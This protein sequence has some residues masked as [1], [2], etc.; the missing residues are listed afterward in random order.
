MDTCICFWF[1]ALLD[2]LADNGVLSGE[3]VV[4]AVHVVAVKVRWAVASVIGSGT[5]ISDRVR[6]FRP[7]SVWS[8]GVSM[9]VVSELRPVSKPTLFKALLGHASRSV[10]PSKVTI[11]AVCRQSHPAEPPHLVRRSCARS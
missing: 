8:S 6:S 4:P 5:H 2:E 10:A 3:M 7:S 11:H 9:S 1:A